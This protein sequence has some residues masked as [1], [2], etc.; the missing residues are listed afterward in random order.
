[1]PDLC[2]SCKAPIRWALTPKGSLMPLDPE[3]DR[4]GEWKVVDGWPSDPPRIVYVPPQSR[5]GLDGQLW[6][7]HWASCPYA[8]QHRRRR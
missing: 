4:E 8:E 1:M 6:R 7:V 2:A 5:V 3:P